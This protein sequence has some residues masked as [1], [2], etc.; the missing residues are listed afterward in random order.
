MFEVCRCLG[1]D[2][3]YQRL[4]FAKW[5]ISCVHVDSSNQHGCLRYDVGFLFSWKVYP[6]LD[7]RTGVS[8]LSVAYWSST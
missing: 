4:D 1:L 2:L 7:S 6:E 5:L 8:S 3:V